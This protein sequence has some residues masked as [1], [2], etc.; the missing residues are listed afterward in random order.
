M[1]DERAFTTEQIRHWLEGNRFLDIDGTDC[2]LWNLALDEAID[3][4][5]DDREGIA[6]CIDRDERDK[7]E[8]KPK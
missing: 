3:N 2:G 6:A 4:V 7:L 8:R 5:D 1:T